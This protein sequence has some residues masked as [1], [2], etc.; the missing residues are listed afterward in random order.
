[1]EAQRDLIKRYALRPTEAMAQ[2]AEAGDVRAVAL[3]EHDDCLGLST[4]VAMALEE[5]EA[6]NHGLV[7]ELRHR[8]PPGVDGSIRQAPRLLVG[9]ATYAHIRQ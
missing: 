2:P 8:L 3:V 1:M 6:C 7:G 5:G 9:S 4:H